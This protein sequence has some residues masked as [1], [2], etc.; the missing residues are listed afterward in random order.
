M[1]MKTYV[2]E[3]MRQ[4]CPYLSFGQVVRLSDA[5]KIIGYKAIGFKRTG[6]VIWQRGLL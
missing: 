5:S 6:E 3:R 1:N 2:I 4:A